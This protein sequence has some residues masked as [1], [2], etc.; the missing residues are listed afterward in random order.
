M[1]AQTVTRRMSPAT[2]T[3]LANLQRE[4][5]GSAPVDITANATTTVTIVHT[6]SSGAITIDYA[7]T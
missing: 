1:V 6:A 5:A 3:R 4:F 7:S 2:V